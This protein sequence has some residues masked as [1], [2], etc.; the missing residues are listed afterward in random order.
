MGGLRLAL[1]IM[2][3]TSYQ[4]LKNAVISWAHASNL[5][6]VVDDF[7][8]IAENDIFDHVRI[9]QMESREALTTSTTSRYI[10]LPDRFLQVKRVDI[11]YS[12]LLYPLEQIT[13]EQLNDEYSTLAGIPAYYSI[14]GEEMQFERLSD[15]AYTGEILFWQ[16]P[17]ALSDSNTMNSILTNYPNIYLYKCMAVLEPWRVNDKRMP[18]WE[19]LYENAVRKANLAAR[20]G[21]VTEGPIHARTR[22]ATP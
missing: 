15:Q 20:K 16:K 8:T 6:S 11:T 13:D 18:Q 19:G 2:A 21:L 7:I 3:I 12:E 10:D 17:I 14:S 5:T 1:F 9:R 4:E 22:R